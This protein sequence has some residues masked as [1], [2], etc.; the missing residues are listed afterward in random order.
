MAVPPSIEHGDL[1]ELADYYSKRYAAIFGDVRQQMADDIERE[2]RRIAQII[3]S[4][5][6]LH[7]NSNIKEDCCP[8]TANSSPKVRRQ[9][10]YSVRL[11]SLDVPQPKSKKKSS[12]GKKKAKRVPEIRTEDSSEENTTPSKPPT[13][14]KEKNVDRAQK[15]GNSLM[16]K[17]N[18]IPLPSSDEDTSLKSPRRNAICDLPSDQQQERIQA[19]VFIKRFGRDEY[20]SENEEAIIVEKPMSTVKKWASLSDGLVHEKAVRFSVRDRLRRK[21]ATKKD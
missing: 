5:R 15:N 2:R 11:P 19:R 1:Q 21:A 7:R 6:E 17:T 8:T 10:I 20:D 13:K 4:A 3:A 18:L 12:K 16:I 14:K 9:S